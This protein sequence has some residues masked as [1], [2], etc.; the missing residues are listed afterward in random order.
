MT[1]HLI[2]IK[3][4]LKSS[5]TDPELKGL[6]SYTY[7]VS[8]FMDHFGSISF[9]SGVPRNFHNADGESCQGNRCVIRAIDY[10]G[11]VMAEPAALIG[12]W[13]IYFILDKQPTFSP[14][15]G[16]TVFPSYTEIFDLIFGFPGTY[17]TLRAEG[18]A[19]RFEVLFDSG[20][21]GMVED[22]VTGVYTESCAR[23]LHVFIKK[24]IPV[25]RFSWTDYNPQL[26]NVQKNAVYMIGLHN[27]VPGDGAVNSGRVRIFFE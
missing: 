22:P 3:D 6:K 2:T 10:H 13:R 26:D 27:G 24:R 12:F 8:Q 9:M 23:G 4:S 21:Q 15:L 17:S 11:A 16:I 7:G 1:N 19:S 25:Q 14:A 5:Y 20:Q 18:L